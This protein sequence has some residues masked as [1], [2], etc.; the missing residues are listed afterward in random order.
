MSGPARIVVAEDEDADVMLLRHAL[1]RAKLDARVTFT[2]DGQETIDALQVDDDTPVL[3]LLDLHMPRVDGFE[4]LRWLRYHPSSRRVSVVILSSSRE[5]EVIKRA[6]ALGASA[7]IVKPEDPFEL[8]R[9]IERVQQFWETSSAS[10]PS[11][12]SS[13]AG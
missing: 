11:P 2:R 4:V 12:A 3:L 1:V 6:G 9:I 13:V 5:S 10:E 7:Y 8:E